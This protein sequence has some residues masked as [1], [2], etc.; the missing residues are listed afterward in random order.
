MLYNL[1]NFYWLSIFLKKKKKK[2]KKKG[3]DFVTKHNRMRFRNKLRHVPAHVSRS[4][5]D[6]LH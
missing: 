2:K 1:F 6:R 4:S 3:K 5:S